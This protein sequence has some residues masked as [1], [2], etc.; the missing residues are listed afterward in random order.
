MSE[1]ISLR[2]KD[3]AQ[4]IIKAKVKVLGSYLAKGIPNGAFVPCNEASFRRWEDAS[5][6][7][8]KIGSPNT[9]NKPYNRALKQR[10]RE[11][12][13]QLAILALRQKLPALKSRAQHKDKEK[14]RLIRNLTGQWHEVKQELDRTQLRER[15]LTN[16]VAELL[17][18]N[19][20]LTRKLR[21]V[22][23]LESAGTG[24]GGIRGDNK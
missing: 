20:N 9:M 14:D 3:K 7:L 6:G 18:E 5:L 8:E 15:R 21:V 22:T 16:R 12:L 23:S 10:V 11:I 24:K 17:E 1:H 4:E 19:A 13:K 2:R